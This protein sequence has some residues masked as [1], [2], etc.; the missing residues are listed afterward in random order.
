MVNNIKDIVV[1]LYQADGNG[2]GSGNKDQV[3]NNNIYIEGT[4][5]HII[6]DI[7]EEKKVLPLPAGSYIKDDGKTTS[8]GL[9]SLDSDIGASYDNL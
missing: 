3:S 1:V 7:E 4:P 2:G 8:G 6:L 5:D 9:K